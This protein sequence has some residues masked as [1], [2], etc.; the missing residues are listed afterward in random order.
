VQRICPWLA[1]GRIT[2]RRK[3]S[4]RFNPLILMDLL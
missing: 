1:L 2:M 3:P 4:P